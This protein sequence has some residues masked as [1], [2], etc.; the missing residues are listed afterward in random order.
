MLKGMLTEKKKLI[1]LARFR[2]K[3]GQSNRR[4]EMSQ[5]EGLSW[6][7]Q[8]RESFMESLKEWKGINVRPNLSQEEEDIEIFGRFNP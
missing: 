5:T 2:D 1:R 6:R 8:R 3:V 7:V 4:L